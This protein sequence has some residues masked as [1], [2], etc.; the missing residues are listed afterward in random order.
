MYRIR[1]INK[2]SVKTIRRNLYTLKKRISFRAS[3]FTRGWL[4]FYL[5]D[6]VTTRPCA[7]TIL[8]KCSQS[9][10]ACRI[11]I[12]CISQMSGGKCECFFAP[13]PPRVTRTPRSPR[14]CS[15]S[16]EKRKKITPFLQA[17]CVKPHPHEQIFCD[18]V[19]VTT[20]I[21]PCT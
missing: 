20:F 9:V 19:Y 17:K 18:N 7:F 21:C 8:L 15:R 11:D 2:Y 12:I 13:L 14:A 6:H 10:V 4:L 5:G 3:L 16:P 1:N